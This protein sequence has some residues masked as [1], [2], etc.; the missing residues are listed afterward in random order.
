MLVEKPVA[1]TVAASQR[2]A[3]RGRGR[4]R[5][6]H[7]RPSPAP[8]PDRAA[9]ARAHGSRGRL[10]RPVRAGPRWR[11]G[12]KPDAYFD[13]AG[14]ASRAAGPVLINLIHDIDQLRFLFG[15]VATVQAIAS[16]AVRGFAV[17][18]TVVVLLRFRNGAL[19]TVTVSDTA[20]APWNWDLA[21]GEAERF[22]RQDVNSHYLSGT[23]A[24][25]TLP[26]LEFWHYRNGK[27]WHDELTQERGA[28]HLG[29]PFAE[30]MRHFRAVLAG[31]EPALSPATDATKSLATTLAV[32]EASATGA[33]VALGD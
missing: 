1:G 9:G 33:T 18:D 16:N 2:L 30:E 23:D 7:R 3:R 21:A 4:R 10:G 26:R 19:G 14:G 27:G 17:E 22:P 8:Q 32:S 25:L 6:G 24:S 15:D 28:L 13:R 29:D 5:A 31:T 11:P 20:V 12:C